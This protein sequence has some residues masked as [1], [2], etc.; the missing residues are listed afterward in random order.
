M[1]IMALNMHGKQGKNLHTVYVWHPITS[2]IACTAILREKGKKCDAPSET[3]WG[4]GGG[5]LF[6]IKK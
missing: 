2:P 1:H 5:C 6:Y 4:G 3:D